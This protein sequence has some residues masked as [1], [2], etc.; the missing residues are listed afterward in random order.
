[1]NDQAHDTL[2]AALDLLERWQD[3]QTGACV[4]GQINPLL[5]DTAALLAALKSF[6]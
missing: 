3:Y 2:L 4:P 1:M 5:R 6:A